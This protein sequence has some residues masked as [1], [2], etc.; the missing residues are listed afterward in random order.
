M[1]QF[2]NPISGDY[3]AYFEVYMK[4]LTTD[5]RDILPILEDQGKQIFDGLKDLTEEKANHSYA[6]GKWTVKEIVGH[7]IDMERLFAFRTLWIARNEVNVQPGVDENLWAGKSN[8]HLRPLVDLRQ[9][10]QG[11]RLSH[12]QLF[13]SL[14]EEALKR[15]ALVD[16]HSTTVNAIPWLVAAHE[17]H[18][19]VVLRDRYGVNLMK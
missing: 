11:M 16:G 8:A 2:T 5:G 10:Y 13:R 18:H 6:P 7:L 17:G 19:L 14:D 15:R 9:E 3:A 4:Q 1:N 12:L